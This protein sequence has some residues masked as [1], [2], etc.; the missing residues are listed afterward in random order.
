MMSY[1]KRIAFLFCTLFFYQ[2]GCSQSDT[3]LTGLVLNK[4]FDL[5]ISSMIKQTIPVIGVED[6]KNIQ[7]E[8]V[9]FDARNKE[10]YEVSHIPGAHFLGYKDF[11]P[12][13]LKDIP[14]DKKIILYCSIGYRSEKI[15]EKLNKLGYTNV[16]NLYGSIFEWA[17]RGYPLLDDKENKIQ[18]VHTYNFSWSKWINN[19]HIEKV[20]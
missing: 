8:V 9:I 3:K 12:E 1:I 13:Q 5:K 11:N 2:F 14:K 17:N 10:E 6:L 7:N 16:Y 18:R 19:E 15:G 20:W 4:N